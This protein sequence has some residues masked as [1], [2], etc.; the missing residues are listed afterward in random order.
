M[1]VRGSGRHLLGADELIE[2]AARCGRH[3]IATDALERLS[4]TAQAGGTDWALGVEARSR[5][6]VSEDDAADALYREA[7][8]RLRRTRVRV[9]LA[10]SHLV[11][12]EWLRRERR[13]VEAREQLR[14][15]YEMLSEMGAEAFA[16]R[17]RRELA[18][19]G[20]TAR[21]RTDETRDE[22]T[23]Q[24]AQIA[25][26]ARDGLSNP[27]IGAELFISPRTVKYHLRKVFTKL[28]IS[29]RHELL[30]ALPETSRAGDGTL[31][32]AYGPARSHDA[33]CGTRREVQRADD[34]R[35]PRG[36]SERRAHRRRARRLV[37]GQN[38]GAQP[39]RSGAPGRGN[40]KP[41]GPRRSHRSGRVP[42]HRGQALRAA[43][44]CPRPREGPGG[45]GR[46]SDHVRLD[47]V[48]RIRAR[49]GR[50][51]DRE[52]EGRRRDHPRQNGYVRLRRGLV[53][54]LVA[55]RPHQESIRPRARVW[56]LERRDGRGRG[57]QFRAGRDRGGH[58]RI[59]PDS[60]RVQQPIWSPRHDRADQSHRVLATCAFPGHPGAGRSDRLRPR[61]DARQSSS[62]TTRRTRS[63]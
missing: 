33:G 40:R 3:E 9:E 54:V 11:Y 52:I 24:E 23:A 53:L 38:R 25:R 31:A 48:H 14:T 44:R 18:A 60:R 12:G 55:D 36:A 47:P 43:P 28:D 29:S 17:A 10:R 13:R 49:E 51:G 22:L 30:T 39:C 19:T 57:R 61:D 56:R 20:E 62:A 32:G 2:A 1:R 7:I 63:Q 45:N 35:F 16:E 27:E 42:R 34:P 59:D 8:G 46:S 6:L 26:L 41:E 4:L 21:K 50:D 15:A 58:R 37:P 5:A